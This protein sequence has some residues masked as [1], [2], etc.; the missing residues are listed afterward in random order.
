MVNVPNPLRR[1][2]FRKDFFRKIRG[3]FHFQMRKMLKDGYQDQYRLFRD[4]GTINIF[5]VGANV[6]DATQTYL[7]LFPQ[8]TIYA[9]EPFPD[10]VAE[11]RRKLDDHSQVHVCPVALSDQVGMSELFI[12][13]ASV[14]NSLIQPIPSKAWGFGDTPETV[15]V[16]TQTVDQICA[17]ENLDEIQIMKLDVQGGELKVLS[18]S[19][20]LLSQGNIGLIYTEMLIVPLYEEQPLFHDLHSFLSKY[21]YS[22]FNLYS[23]RESPLGQ[24]RWADA[25]FVGPKLRD[26]LTSKLGSGYCGW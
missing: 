6:G 8:A 19:K 26:R 16:E 22:L 5:D 12:S 25:I 17:D 13:N 3:K 11:L 14:M 2:L 7:K 23:L 18:G 9:F 20:Q 10:T 4:F 1:Y 15:M 24:I 21:D